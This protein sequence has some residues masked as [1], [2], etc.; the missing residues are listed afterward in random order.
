[1]P[2]EPHWRDDIDA[3]TFRPT[4]HEGCCVVHRLAFRRLLSFT[5]TANDCVAF[6][7]ARAAEFQ[8]G[9]ATKIAHRELPPDANFHLTSR[10]L[11]QILKRVR[12]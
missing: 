6:F 4:A 8:A 12:L 3:L 2:Q 5:P 7:N 1:V 9:A 10:D 11:A